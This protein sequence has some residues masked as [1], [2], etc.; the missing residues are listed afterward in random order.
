MCGPKADPPQDG[1]R[2]RRGRNSNAVFDTALDEDPKH[3]AVA[4]PEMQDAPP[5][6]GMVAHNA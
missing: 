4:E 3:Q 2:A 6:M 1:G 5:K